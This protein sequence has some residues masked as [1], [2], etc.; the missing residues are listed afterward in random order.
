M[1]QD[2]EGQS[3]D[4]PS[5]WK[6]ERTISENG[7]QTNPISS[8]E[9]MTQTKEMNSVMVQTDPCTIKRLKEVDIDY[10]SLSGFLQRVAPVVCKY[11]EKNSHTNAFDNYRLLRDEEQSSTRIIYTLTYKI[12]SEFQCL[13][14]SWNSTG[15]VLAVAYG[16]TSHS[17]WC[18]HESNVAIWNVQR[19]DF[20]PNKPNLTIETD[21][22]VT[23]I[24]FHPEKPAVLAAGKFNGEIVIWDIGKDDDMQLV[25]LQAHRE[26]I[27]GVHW[28]QN[29]EQT[30][31]LV[32][33]LIRENKF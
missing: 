15:T 31:Y 26:L 19:K 28:I 24:A 1:F 11:L 14:A 5:S 29:E 2:G 27:T 18:S 23:A 30:E 22:C 12:P 25:D 33:I 17:D 3:S 9:S 6:T 7:I 8:V 16:A 20:V 21:S 10:D 13:D 4:F 32:C